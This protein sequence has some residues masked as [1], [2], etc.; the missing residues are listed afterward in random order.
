M[1]NLSTDKD[2]SLISAQNQQRKRSN[3]LTLENT[4][5]LLLRKRSNSESS[6]SNATTVVAF[7]DH[8][9]P[10]QKKEDVGARLLSIRGKP[11]I[12]KR[13]LLVIPMLTLMVMFTGVDVM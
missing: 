6:I 2:T 11:G 8:Q 13:N 10:V 3:T 12:L 4:P 9:Y 1:E 7:S 5:A